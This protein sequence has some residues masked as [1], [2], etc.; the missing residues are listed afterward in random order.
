MIQ[1]QILRP[2]NIKSLLTPYWFHPSLT[3]GTCQTLKRSIMSV[4]GGLQ[5]AILIS[6]SSKEADLEL[7]WK[8]YRTAPKQIFVLK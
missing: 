8:G 6:L 7:L 1:W 2:L 4:N 3:L 5:G